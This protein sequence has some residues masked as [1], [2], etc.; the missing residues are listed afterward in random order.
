ML[1]YRLSCARLFSKHFTYIKAF[2]PHNNPYKILLLSPF[3]SLRNWAINIKQFTQ[4]HKGCKWQSWDVNQGSPAPWLMFL[5]P[6]LYYFSPVSFS[7]IPWFQYQ[8]LGLVFKYK[9]SLIKLIFVPEI[10]CACTPSH[11]SHVWLFATLWTVAHQASLAMGFSRQEYKSGFLCPPPVDLP[12]PG[13]EPESPELQV[14]SLLLN[15]TGEVPKYS[16]LRASLEQ[17]FRLLALLAKAGQE[18]DFVF[19]SQVRVLKDKRGLI[20]L[21]HSFL[22][23]SHIYWQWATGQEPNKT[24]EI[25]GLKSQFLTL[26]TSKSRVKGKSVIHRISSWDSYQLG[27]HVSKE[28]DRKESYRRNIYIIEDDHRKIYLDRQSSKG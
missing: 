7:K 10:L 24:V 28:Q 26:R 20:F 4:V 5:M 18:N 19:P 8:K 21:I 27:W 22:P 14:D 16:L 23:F 6:M 11:F 9:S 13:T 2:D 3:C 25:R 17:E 12:N 1:L 15:P